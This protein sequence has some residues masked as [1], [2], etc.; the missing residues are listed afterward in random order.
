ML[1]VRNSL[2]RSGCETCE[3]LAAAV[4]A[5]EAA[6]AAMLKLPDIGR[7]ATKQQSRSDFVD[8]WRKYLPIEAEI[9]FTQLERP[10]TV[11]ALRA[12]L[13]RLGGGKQR[14]RL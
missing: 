8:A 11:A 7:S 14:S 5:A 1:S 6:M 13:E 4:S 12:V 10:A 3:P 2:T 9:G